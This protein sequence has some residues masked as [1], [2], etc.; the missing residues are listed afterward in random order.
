MNTQADAVRKACAVIGSQAALARDLG[1]QPPTVAQWALPNDAPKFRP[2]PIRFCR[3]VAELAGCHVSV[4]RPN[5]WRQIWPDTV[6]QE[7]IARKHL[8]AEM[9]GLDK[10]PPAQEAAHG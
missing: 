1:V 6:L 3:R 7:A 9:L 5:D 4:L 10:Q 2:M 8:P